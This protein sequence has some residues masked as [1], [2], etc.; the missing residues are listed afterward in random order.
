MIQEE[1]TECAVCKCPLRR[2]YGVHTRG[3]VYTRT[4]V[5]DQFL[6]SCSEACARR[7]RGTERPRFGIVLPDEVRR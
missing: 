3:T 4:L 2:S 5:K 7:L 6:P 1:M